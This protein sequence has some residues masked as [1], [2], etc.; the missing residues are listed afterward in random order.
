LQSNKKRKID[1]KQQQR[2]IIGA[3]IGCLFVAGLGRVEAKEIRFTGKFAGTSL[4]SRIDRNDDGLP[5]NW[6]TGVTKGTLGNRIFQ[7]L[8]ESVPT[9]PTTECPGGVFVIDA[10]NG[11]G[12]GTFTETFPN[13]DQYYARVLTFTSCS[14]SAGGYTGSTTISIVGGTGKFAGAS[15]NVE[16]SFVGFFQTGDA[17]AVPRQA[18]GPFSGEFTGTLILP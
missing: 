14:D 13:G 2:L 6:S 9:G 15:G 10:Q 5:A 11:Q 8:Y 12:F 3:A 16:N 18:F 4:H 7:T 1:M 17:N